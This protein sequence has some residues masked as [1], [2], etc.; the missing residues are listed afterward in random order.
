M[1]ALN[2]TG[3]TIAFGTSSYSADILSINGSGITRPS[4]DTSHMGSTVRTFIPGDLVD[5]GTVE[6][7]IIFDPDDQPPISAAA[8]TITI[9]FNSPETTGAQAAGSGFVT[10]WEFGAPL[11]DKMTGTYTIKWAGAV[12]W[13]DATS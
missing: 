5:N 6:V 10:D 2:G 12:T 13:T 11:E 3:A 4:I 7:E 8:E 9:E 1:A